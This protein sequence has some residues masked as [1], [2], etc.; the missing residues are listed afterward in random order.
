VSGTL[1]EGLKVA[2]ESVELVV[3]HAVINVALALVFQL[4]SACRL[5]VRPLCRGDVDDASGC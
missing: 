3:R 4:T 5:A 1:R 2:R